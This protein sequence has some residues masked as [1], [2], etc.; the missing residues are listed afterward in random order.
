VAE[1]IDITLLARLCQDTLAETRVIR[2]DLADVRRD[3]GDVHRDL[4]DMR[5]DLGDVRRDLTDVQKLAI[6][7]VEV[8]TKMEKRNEVRYA[9]VDRRFSVVDARLNGLD[10]RI[11]DLKDDLQ[12]MIK[13]EL[14]G[15]LGNF[16]TRMISLIDERFSGRE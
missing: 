5:R 14:M 1:N 8:L 10:Q 6:K 15:A 9:A 16:E 2:H 12:L 11:G 7:T 4:G 3:L 13:S